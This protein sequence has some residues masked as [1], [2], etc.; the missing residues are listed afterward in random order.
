MKANKYYIT[1]AALFCVLTGNA[2][3]I[4]KS[5]VEVIKTQAEVKGDSLYVDIDMSL[6]KVKTK[7]QESLL[8][9]PV[10]QAGQ[11]IT[12]LPSVLVSGKKRFKAY[13]RA[14]SYGEAPMAFLSLR[15]GKEESAVVNYTYTLAYQPWM[16]NAN[17]ALKEEIYG[18][19][20]CQKMIAWIP[21]L[22][23]VTLPIQVL[24]MMVT[25]VTPPVET[26]K[27][28]DMQGQAFLDFPVNKATILPDFRRNP[29]ELGK[30]QSAV[31][32]VKNN[33]Y[34]TITSIDL[35]GYASPE[36]PAEL[37]YNLSKDRSLALKT[38]LQDKY[39]YKNN[40]FN[41]QWKGEDWEGLKKLVEDSN[42][43]DKSSL[44][45]IITSTE[46]DAVKDRRIKTYA[47]GAPYRILLDEYYPLLRRVEYRLNYTVQ[48][49]TVTQG[50]EILK[51]TP[52]Q[53]SLNEMFLV[54][55]TYPKGSKEFNE[56]FDIA[57]RVFP[58]DPIANI[59]AGASVL[60]KGDTKEAHRYLDKLSDMPQAWNNIGVMYFMEGDFK[61]AGEYLNKAKSANPKEADF[62][63]EQLNNKIKIMERKN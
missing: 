62:N 40:L 51:V 17:V 44:L 24:P 13:K 8:L 31:E 49:F 38:Y 27:N 61:R 25:Y 15:S 7:A 16:E 33:R 30:I 32:Q 56:V 11:Q 22:N 55:N 57:V 37:N 21:L 50:I 3:T 45:E 48:A 1:L 14:Q 59:N 6:E 47:G 29:V 36:G 19:A 60:E 5:G 28:R 54:A 39:G 46:K 58:Q 43:K 23:N 2:Q 52:G 41:V 34:A 9:T 42:L 12:E 63:N 4:G 20:E 18:C 26:V 10:I 53:M 35:T